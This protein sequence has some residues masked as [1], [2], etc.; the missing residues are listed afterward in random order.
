MADRRKI[1]MKLRQL[2]ILID[3]NRTVGELLEKS[4]YK[5]DT[6]AFEELYHA[7]MI[8]IDGFTPRP[9]G[10]PS[11]DIAPPVT[12]SEPVTPAPTV[13]PTTT[14]SMQPSLSQLRFQALDILLDLSME[15]FSI[16]PWIDTFEKANTVEELVALIQQFVSSGLDSRH[17]E[18]GHRLLALC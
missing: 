15:D 9:T 10:E 12:I 7:G 18:Y 16:R 17:A 4:L 11:L 2:M 1:D 5:L 6:Q 14:S 13:A 8:E 3:G